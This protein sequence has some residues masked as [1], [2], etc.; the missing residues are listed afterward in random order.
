MKEMLEALK[1]VNVN[2]NSADL[3][4]VAK[5]WFWCNIVDNVTS[6]IGWNLFAVILAVGVYKFAKVKY[7]NE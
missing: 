2:L 6:F 3:V 1:G 7:S 5:Y 4:G